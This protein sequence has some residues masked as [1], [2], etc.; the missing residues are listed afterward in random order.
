MRKRLIASL[1]ALVL[2]FS[3]L[4]GVV[5]AED[6]AHIHCLCGQTTQKDTLCA[7]CGEKA[8]AWI[9]S[10]TMP[11][12]SGNYY[13]TGPVSAGAQ[14]LN[15]GEKISLCLH[16]Q[17]VTSAA[18]KK[19]LYL[20]K[21][22]VYNITDCTATTQGDQYIAGKLTGTTGTAYFSANSSARRRVSGA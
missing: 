1:L 20:N 14:F 2:V 15:N 10:S 18:G 21:Q 16:G 4:P 13:L 3:L 8:V 7:Q 5:I 9:A 12:E 11:T 17:T 6:D 22:N 19:F